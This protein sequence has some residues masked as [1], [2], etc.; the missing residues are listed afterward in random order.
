MESRREVVYGEDALLNCYGKDK[1]GIYTIEIDEGM[2]GTFS[3]ILLT[4]TQLD[5]LI[6]VLTELKNKTK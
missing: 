4:Q 6:K 1:Q 3:S 2:S 5:E